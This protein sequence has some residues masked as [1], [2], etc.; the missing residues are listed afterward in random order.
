MIG[1]LNIL[2]FQPTFRQFETLFPVRGLCYNHGVITKYLL[3]HF[4]SLRSCF[5][6]GKTETAILLGYKDPRMHSSWSDLVFC[7]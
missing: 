3:K 7:T 2:N 5:V 6:E 4:I 1:D